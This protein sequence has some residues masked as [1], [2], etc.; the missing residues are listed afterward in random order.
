MRLD[1]RSLIIHKWHAYLET[2]TQIVT[3]ITSKNKLMEA[4]PPLSS[5]LAQYDILLVH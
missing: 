2:I 1:T 5:Y 3:Y 4:L